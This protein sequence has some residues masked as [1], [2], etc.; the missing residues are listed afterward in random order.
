MTDLE[1][2][3]HK[4]IN[5]QNYAKTVGSHPEEAIKQAGVEPTPEKVSAL[6]SAVEALK[7]AHSHFGGMRPD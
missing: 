5:D 7:S 1:K 4:A 6:K 3:L 2:I